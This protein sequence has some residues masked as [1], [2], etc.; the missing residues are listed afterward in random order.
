MNVLLTRERARADRVGDSLSV[1]A[2]TPRTSECRRETV[3]FLARFLHRRLRCTDDAGWLDS[4]RIGVL[5]PGTGL[6]GART[7]AD[8]VCEA[9]PQ[10]LPRPLCAIYSYPSSSA[11]S[12]DSILD[13]T[14]KS[15][16]APIQE[17]SLDLLFLKPF[18]L[19]KRFVDVLAA[20]LGLVLLSP[21]LLLA[22]LAIKL[23]SRG[24]VFFWQWRTGWEGK[25]FLIYKFRT[26]V[27]D[28]EDRK[29]SL[30]VHSQQ[31]GPAFKM[32]NDP[33]VTFVGRFLRCTSLDELPQLWNILKGDM[34]L[35]GPRPLP[36]EEADA[37]SGWQRHRLDI[38][39]GLTC[40]W[41]VRGRSRV[42]FE[43]WIRMDLRYIRSQSFLLDMLLL[44]LTI[45]AVL[46]R[47]GAH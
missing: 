10:E 23:T 5:L 37:C 47:R 36:C 1:V 22:A 2:F 35:V 20:G 14:T 27:L 40:I 30:R 42:S 17:F 38:K 9:F 24:P 41:Q 39:P 28:A 31:D 34:S 33:R 26:M 46:S 16:P 29:A 45:P 19:W 44:F 15:V 8:N 21:L 6:D 7:L 43:D 18:P 3:A 13:D 25:P 32:T 11:D 12:V 4:E